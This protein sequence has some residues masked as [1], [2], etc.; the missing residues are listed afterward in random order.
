MA[1]MFRL[2]STSRTSP[3]RLNVQVAQSS[4]LVSSGARGFFGASR[5]LAVTG[6]ARGELPIRGLVTI[7]VLLSQSGR[8]QTAMLAMYI[9]QMSD[10]VKCIRGTCQNWTGVL[11]SLICAGVLLADFVVSSLWLILR[12]ASRDA[13]ANCTVV[14]IV[15]ADTSVT[16]VELKQRCGT[17]HLYPLTCPRIPA[18]GRYGIYFAAHISRLVV[19]F[20][21]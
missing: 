14:Q 7:I 11:K 16:C 17:A 15:G 19:P 9:R 5:L 10:G 1:R 18:A 13:R 2:R 3:L 6:R 20:E 21:S 4:L 12:V 8:G